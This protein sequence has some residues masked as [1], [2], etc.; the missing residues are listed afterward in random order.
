MFPLF[1]CRTLMP[2]LSL[3]MQS[4]H[5]QFP[6]WPKQGAEQCRVEE[7]HRP[8]HRGSKAR[9]RDQHSALE[10][11]TAHLCP[12]SGQWSP[13][14]AGVG[15]LMTGYDFPGGWSMEVLEDMAR[16]EHYMLLSG[17]MVFTCVCVRERE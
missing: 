1:S 2:L 9:T 17:S 12:W 6:L 13:G 3:P 14:G 7:D 16:S 11:R 8:V 4:I 15:A 10:L 5:A